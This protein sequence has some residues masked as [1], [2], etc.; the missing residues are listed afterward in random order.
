MGVFLRKFF[1]LLSILFLFSCDSSKIDTFNSEL[2]NIEQHYAPDKSIAVFD[3]QLHKDS[4]DWVLK[5]ETTSKMAKKAI[6]KNAKSILGDV[7][8]K[9][10]LYVLPHPDLKGDTV[11][12]A[13]VS[14]VNLREERGVSKQ[15]VDQVILGDRLRVL[16]KVGRWY[17]VQTEYGYL[18]WVTRYSIERLP[19]NSDWFTNPMLQVKSL[20]GN[21]YSEPSEYSQVVCDVV[22]NAKINQIGKG[23]KWLEVALSKL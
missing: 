14:I 20:N 5:G 21:I 13:K 1:L 16:N 11:A 23:F 19:L 17:L 18:G 10:S 3:V 4:K 7:E 2:K 8:L 12:V 22:L 15:L 9:D 6:L